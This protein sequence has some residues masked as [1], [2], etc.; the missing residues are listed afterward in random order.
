[1]E[2]YILVK[3][4]KKDD[5]AMRYEFTAYDHDGNEWSLGHASLDHECETFEGFFDTRSVQFNSTYDLQ[6]WMRKHGYNMGFVEFTE[7]SL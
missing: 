1:M 5:K 6:R 7:V 2:N 3:I 4:I